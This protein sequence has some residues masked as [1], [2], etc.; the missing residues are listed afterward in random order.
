MC[1]T[2]LGLS[3]S[4]ERASF[5]FIFSKRLT[6]KQQQTKCDKLHYDVRHGWAVTLVSMRF[7]NVLCLEENECTSAR[8]GRCAQTRKT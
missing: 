5:S 7:L 6:V 4:A 2:W 1:R 3:S 8:S